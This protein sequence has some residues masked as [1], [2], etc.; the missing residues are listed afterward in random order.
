MMMMIMMENSRNAQ[1]IGNLFQFSSLRHKIRKGFGSR[2][3]GAHYDSTETYLHKSS[4]YFVILHT[5]ILYTGMQNNENG[6]K[7]FYNITY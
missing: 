2:H 1:L 4:R 7:L 3:S 5:G 6:Q